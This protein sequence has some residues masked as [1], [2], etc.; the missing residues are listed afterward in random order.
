MPLKTIVTHIMSDSR[1]TVLAAIRGYAEL[2]RR[3]PQPSPPD[4]AHALARIESESARMTALVDDLLL[5]ARLDSGRPLVRQPV[6]LTQLLVDA[7]G[8][9]H[10][11]SP[12]HQWRLDLPDA[13]VSVPGDPARL[14]QVLANLLANA[15]THTPPGSTVTASLSTTD[16]RWAR[17]QVSTM[18][19]P[20]TP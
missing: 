7:V 9:A 10:A 3:G 17:I 13:V 5:L 16:D 18:W 1:A 20:L 19:R 6:D 8:D 2:T 15:G 12:D 11:A 14:H 4:V